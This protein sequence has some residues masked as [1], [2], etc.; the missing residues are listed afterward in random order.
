[1]RF[2]PSIRRLLLPE[3]VAESLTALRGADRQQLVAGKPAPRLD[4]APRRRILHLDFQQLTGGHVPQLHLDS[5]RQNC[6]GG[7]L[8]FG[9]RVHLQKRICGESIPRGWDRLETAAEQ[10]E[11]AERIISEKAGDMLLD[12]EPLPLLSQEE[13]VEDGQLFPDAMNL[14]LLDSNKIGIS[15]PLLEPERPAGSVTF[16]YSRQRVISCNAG[17]IL[18]FR[19]APKCKVESRSVPGTARIKLVPLPDVQRK[20]FGPDK[21]SRIVVDLQTEDRVA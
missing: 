7:A 14:R 11:P 8:V 13:P 19:R 18:Y 12:L 9:R 1:M 10:V 16:R 15:E 17:K 20:I 6:A 3:E 2:S 21:R 4:I 5:R